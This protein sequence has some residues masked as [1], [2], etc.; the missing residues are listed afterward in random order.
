VCHARCD[1]SAEFTPSI[2]IVDA[3][4]SEPLSRLPFFRL[5]YSDQASTDP[6]RATWIALPTFRVTYCPGRSGSFEKSEPNPSNPATLPVNLFISISFRGVLHF[7]TD[8]LAFDLILARVVAAE[9]C[10]RPTSDLY[11][12]RPCQTQRNAGITF[13]ANSS[14]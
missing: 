8:A 9:S 4:L 10:R 12:R 14:R 2:H 5:R 11:M 13:E 7:I 3:S 1:A 6:T